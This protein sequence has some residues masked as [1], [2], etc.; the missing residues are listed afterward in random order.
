VLK[1]RIVDNVEREERKIKII[2]WCVSFNSERNQD[3]NSNGEN[4]A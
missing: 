1:V 4:H 3:V 2:F